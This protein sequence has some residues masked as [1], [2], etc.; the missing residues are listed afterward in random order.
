MKPEIK[1]KWTTALRSGKYKQGKGG[2]C[3]DGKFCCLGVLCDLFV[4]EQQEIKPSNSNRWSQHHSNRYVLFGEYAILPI[5]VMNWAG[6]EEQNPH[7]PFVGSLASTND[8]GMSFSAI[9][10]LIEK[11]L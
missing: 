4:R 9:A 11:N 1:T 10:D 5:E 6:L 2:L 7:I 3:R 8:R